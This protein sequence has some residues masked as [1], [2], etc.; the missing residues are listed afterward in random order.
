MNKQTPSHEVQAWL[1]RVTKVKD[2]LLTLIRDYHPSSVPDPNNHKRMPITAP[3]AEEM[4]EAI[5]Q[6]TKE[7]EKALPSPEQRFTTALEQDNHQEI[8]SLLQMVWV[9]VP[10]SRDCWQIDGFAEMVDLLDDPPDDDTDR[11]QE[12]EGDLGKF[13]ERRDGE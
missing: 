10:E 4:S 12:I 2:K 13:W 1:V 6:E 3:A 5:R 11:P 7:K 9:G 8:Y